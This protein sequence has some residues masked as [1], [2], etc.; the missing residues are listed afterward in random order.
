MA[1]TFDP[2]KRDKARAE[3]DLDFADAALVFAAPCFSFEDDRAD[4][5]EIRIITAGHLAGRMVMVGWTPRGR[6]RHVF[7]M[8]KANDRE[9]V[10]FADLLRPD[11]PAP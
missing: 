2:K 11:D 10:R 1:I 9:K 4:Y 6:N 5:G 3:R 8:R 7:S